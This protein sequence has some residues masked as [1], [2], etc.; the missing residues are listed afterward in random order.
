MNEGTVTVVF[1]HYNASR[2]VASALRYF[3]KDVCQIFGSGMK[4]CAMKGKSQ[5]ITTWECLEDAADA[6]TYL[7]KVQRLGCLVTVI[8]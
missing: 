3:N 2:E 6:A 5:V 4:R 7:A 1:E 8:E